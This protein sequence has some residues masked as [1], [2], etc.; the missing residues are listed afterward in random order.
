MAPGLSNGCVGLLVFL[1]VSS[2]CVP[3]SQHS[4]NQKK[5]ATENLLGTKFWSSHQN[6][7][8]L[9]YDDDKSL[10]AEKL[11]ECKK[12]LA[13]THTRSHCKGA[14]FRSRRRHRCLRFCILKIIGQRSQ[15]DS[16]WSH[17]L[18]DMSDTANAPRQAARANENK[19]NIIEELPRH[20][21]LLRECTQGSLVPLVESAKN[22]NK[23][24]R[25]LSGR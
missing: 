8:H 19:E 17:F 24:Q 21:E 5:A 22:L 1:C 3:T 23:L 15:L 10:S 25:Y 13:S 9:L 14:D 2:T 11:D 18:W 7:I 12:R 4:T 6:M 20:T 16:M